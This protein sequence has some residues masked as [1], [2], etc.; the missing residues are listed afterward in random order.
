LTLPAFIYEKTRG[1]QIIESLKKSATHT[2]VVLDEFGSVVGIVTLNDIV[3]A[4]LGSMPGANG[5]EEEPRLVQDPDGSWLIDG[6][7]PLDEFRDHFNLDEIP[8]G[9]YHTLAG[10]VVTQ[11]GHIPR[12]SESVECLGL[13]IEVVHMDSKRVERVRVSS[14]LKHKPS[15]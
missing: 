1:P 15:V 10:L 9:D 13:N 12:V 6:R 14:A 3:E 11:L 7:F 8:Q 2:A 4:V 5:E